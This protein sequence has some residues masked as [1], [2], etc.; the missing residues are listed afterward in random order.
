MNNIEINILKTFRGL[1]NNF[2]DNLFRVV[3]FLGE[4]Y[5][6]IAVIFIIFFFFD[7]KI[8]YHVMYSV[9]LG[10]CLNNSIKGLIKRPRPWVVDSTYEPASIAKPT[11]TGYS[12]PSGHT[13]N[14]TTL[15]TSV[16]LE[17]KKKIIII[18]SII[19]ICLVGFSRILLGV[20]YPTDVLV[21]LLTGLLTAF[22][23]YLITKFIKD[24]FRKMLLVIIATLI[25][26]TPFVFVFF[27]KDSSQMIWQKDFYVAWFMLLGFLPGYIIESKVVQME[28]SKKFYI[29]LLRFIGCLLMFGVTYLGLKFLFRQ[30]LFPQ[31]DNSFKFIFDGIRYFFV[32]FNCLGLY[33]L[34][35]KNIL[36]KKEQ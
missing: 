1:S 24:E 19:I 35:F 11:A 29:N 5:F 33:P 36:F 34:L 26:F 30:P 3:S 17:F 16:S 2:L 15:L 32:V 18:S 22:S 12:F 10:L 20:H 23:G 14:I 31:D 8:G 21:G 4:Q 13:Q 6:V 27:T 7:K 28:I 9:L 25:V